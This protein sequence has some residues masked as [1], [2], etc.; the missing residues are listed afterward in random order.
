LRISFTKITLDYFS[1]NRIKTHGPEGTDR[2]TGPAA[3]ADIVVVDDPAQFLIPGKGLD[4]AGIH[5]RCILALLTG[6]GDIQAFHL[7]FHDSDAAP[8][9]VGDAVMFHGADQF[10]QSASGTFFIVY[11]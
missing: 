9:G 6:H 10:A 1:V 3:D 8:G 7:P 4:R 11:I 2:D 5:T